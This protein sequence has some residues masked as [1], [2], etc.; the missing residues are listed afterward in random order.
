LV[1]QRFA[2]K[3]NSYRY[4]VGLPFA[5]APEVVLGATIPLVW[6]AV[7]V[8]ISKMKKAALEEGEEG[9]SSDGDRKH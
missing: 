8:A 4:A 5:L 7:S 2:F 3:F 6:G 1:F 9:A